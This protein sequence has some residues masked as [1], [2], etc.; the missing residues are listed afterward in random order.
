MKHQNKRS[1]VNF[2][3]KSVATRKK[4]KIIIIIKE[5]I[6]KMKK[7]KFD[8]HYNPRPFVTIR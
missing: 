3:S 4:I 8:T 6:K 2:P 1:L 5:E 7:E